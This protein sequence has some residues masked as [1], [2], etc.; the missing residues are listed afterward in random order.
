MGERQKT[1]AA[2]ITFGHA[3]FGFALTRAGDL[4]ALQEIMRERA[5][6][7]APLSLG[8][9]HSGPREAKHLAARLRS[10]AYTR[11]PFLLRL[12]YLPH[13]SRTFSHASLFRPRPDMNFYRAESKSGVSFPPVRVVTIKSYKSLGERRTVLATIVLLESSIQA[14]N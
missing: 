1:C 9:S 8:E 5:M 11:V 7:R 12:R 14:L 10:P 2:E 4:I 13:F 6:R 3:K